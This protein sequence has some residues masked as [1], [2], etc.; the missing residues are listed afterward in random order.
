MANGREL[1]GYESLE[2]RP[3]LSH[4][5]ITTWEWLRLCCKPTYK[6]RRVKSKGAILL[7]VWNYLIMNVFGLL[8][9]YLDFGYAFRMWLIAFGLI[10]PLAG[11]LA[12]AHIGR[13]RVIC[14]SIWS[15]WIATVLATLNS[16]MAQ[17][18]DVY[19]YHIHTKAL[20]ALLV[21]MA[22]GLGGYQAN[23]IQF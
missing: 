11:W 18:F 19:I 23:I 3:L 9:K 5:K 12:D 22:I 13:Y 14:C 6:P 2:E 7:L 21:I 20:Q 4:K 16:V 8:I 15:M 1:G 17:L 10:P